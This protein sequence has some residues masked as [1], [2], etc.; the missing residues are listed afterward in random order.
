MKARHLALIILAIFLTNSNGKK[1]QCNYKIINLH[2][3]NQTFVACEFLR[4]SVKSN[5][6]F[7]IVYKEPSNHIFGKILHAKM[8]KVNNFYIGNTTLDT[9]IDDLVTYIKFKHSN[10]AVILNQMILKFPN[11]LIFDASYSKLKVIDSFSFNKIAKLTHIFLHHN[12][13]STI[14]DHVF[15]H[16]AGLEVL[17]LSYNEISSLQ[18]FAFSSLA[19]LEEL[20]LASNKIKSL[21]DRIFNTLENLKWLYLNN[22][23]IMRI[24]SKVFSKTNQALLGIFLQNNRINSLSPIAFEELQSLRFLFL[25][26]NECINLDFKNHVIFENTLIAYELKKCHENHRKMFSHERDRNL[27]TMI[28][29]INVSYAICQGKLM[30]FRDTINKY[31]EAIKSFE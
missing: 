16:S 2:V 29:E 4:A 27:T 12:K 18:K 21:E 9:N 26:A 28:E 10:L 7:E 30:L 19:M 22:N 24:S 5:D 17:D 14:R 25:T 11:S 1:F 15:V 3:L 31:N 13:L 6:T 8:N 20:N 23:L